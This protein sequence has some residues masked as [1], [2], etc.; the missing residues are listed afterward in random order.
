MSSMN[1]ES[2]E[3]RLSRG[4]ATVLLDVLRSEGVRYIFGNPGT[5]EMP[6]LRA[7]DD[8]ADIS[9]V[10]GLQESSVVSMAD[11]YAKASGR[12]AFVNLHASGGLGH[13][14][15]A[16]INS[17]ISNTPLVITA[18]QQDVRHTHMDPLLSGDLVRM[19]RP[20]VKWADEIAIADHLPVKLRRAFQ[21]SRCAPRGPVFLSLPTSMMEQ[22]T[23]VQPGSPSR[24]H[25]DSIAGGLEELTEAICGIPP[26]RLAIIVGDEVF[27]SDASAE[28]VTLAETLGAPVFGSSWPGHIPFPTSH[29]LWQSGLP[30]LAREIRERLRP[31]DAV[32]ALGGHSLITYLYSEGPT[33]PS[34]CRLFQ[35]SDDAHNLGRV[36]TA[37]LG[38]VGDIRSSLQA[39]LPLLKSK[40]ASRKPQVERLLE[41]AARQRR[42][43]R[44][45]LSDRAAREMG[46]SKITPFVA[47]SEALR[48]IGPDTAIVDE[49]PVTM[50][51]VRALLS[52]HSFRQYYFMRSAILGWGM[53]AAVGVSLG[54]DRQPVVC[55]VGD[56]SALYSPQAL[57]TAARERLPVT[58]VVTNNREYNILKT[59]VRQ[60]EGRTARGNDSYIGLD[61][62]HPPIDFCALATSMG[63]PS[64][65]VERA[66][67][68]AAV[69]ESGIA[70]GGPNVV[71]IA[72]GPEPG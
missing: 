30:T 16:I 20:V 57:W 46:Q 67:E 49:S 37:A 47:A 23:T 44:A 59:F 3:S 55:L 43:R 14:M 54:L 4:A 62:T 38:C 64:T 32:F 8:A 24:I 6:L 15:G 63:L 61:L 25:R 36:Y 17:Q 18:G 52:S 70:S 33:L 69:V 21:D 5:T 71:E 1:I 66:S 19:A 31:F 28:A 9:Y 22:V 29:P 39:L 2:I 51:H 58:F 42:L 48:A 27:A 65:R 13:A 34:H 53:P 35:L 68:I 11:G 56:G 10:L 41:Q 40:A 12:T 72:V 50:N 26:G 7:L 60:R 45:D